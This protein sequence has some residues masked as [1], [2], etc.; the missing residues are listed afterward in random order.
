MEF[1]PSLSST[2]FLDHD[3][4]EIRR[5]VE[6]V[7]PDGGQ[8]PRDRAVK[9]Y[10]AVRDRIRYEIYGADLSR[11]GLTASQVLKAG[12]G[13]CL[14]KSVLYVSAL[15]AVD[16]PA[17]IV[18][19]DVRNHLSSEAVR[20]FI[21]GEVF[22]YH[23]LTSLHLGRWIRATPVFNRLLCRLYGIS[24]LEFDGRGDSLHHPY[25][26]NGRAHMEF[27]QE[28]GEFDD[29]PYDQVLDGLRREHPGI[30]TGPAAARF[31]PGS[32]EADARTA[33]APR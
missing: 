28:H 4:P 13:M 5:F 8:D 14:H 20:E 1:A 23:A 24:P 7:L 17:R 25:D 33:P 9:L 12:K 30:F 10:Y 29:L 21:G 6:D 27:L 18:L 16:I 32:L 2:A 19:T 26:E 15:R 11:E 3:S 22:H 31:V